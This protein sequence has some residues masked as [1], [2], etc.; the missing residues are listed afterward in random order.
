MPQT[1]FGNQVTGGA[2][3]TTSFGAQ[4]PAG[5]LPPTSFGNQPSGG[6]PPT[7]FGNASTGGMM[8][9]TLF[10]MQAQPQFQQQPQSF[11]TFG[12]QLQQP[13]QSFNANMN[14]VTNMFQ[15]TSI[16]GTFQPQQPQQQPP[17]T[18]GQSFALNQFEG[19]GEQPLQSQPTGLGFGNG[20][21]QSQQ[22]GRRANLQAATADNP[23]GF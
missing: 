18:F 5:G 8:P 12:Q 17:T 10:G 11:G 13:P 3:P 21:L 9:Q 15:N 23:F 2:M 4:S 19:F 22:T 6:F 1:S 14:Q 16:G 20:P 7:T